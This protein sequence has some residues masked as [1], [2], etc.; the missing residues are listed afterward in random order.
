MKYLKLVLIV[1]LA[2]VST[3][4]AFVPMTTGGN[5]QRWELVNL[6]M[7]VHTNVVNRNTR[8]I[9]YYL[10]AN[11]YSAGNTAAELNAIRASFAQWQAISGTVLKFE[12]AGL[13]N[14]ADVNTTDNSNVVYWA[15]S[16]LV[17]NNLNISGTLGVTY[18]SFSMSGV[19]LQA[20]IVLNGAEND[21]YTD[22][23]SNSTTH[24]F[25]EGVLLHEIGHYIGLHH[26]PVG[27][28]SMLW[29]GG[30]GI[31]G[32][33]GLADDDVSGARLI[34][35][36]TNQLKNLGALTGSV[37]R[38]GSTIFGAAVFLED[39]NGNLVAGTVTDSSGVYRLLAVQPESYQ[40]RVCPLDPNSGDFL[41]RGSEISSAYNAADTSFLPTA[42]IA[43]NVPAGTNTLNL[44]VLSGTA[45]FRITDIRSPTA[46]PNS[47]RWSGT[48]IT[49][50]QGQSNFTVGVVSA[51]LPTSGATLSV[52]GTG[53]SV[54][55][56]TFNANL[57]GTGLN[58]MSV[59][60]SVASNAAPGP[61]TFIVQQ[62][63]NRAYANGFIEIAP[64]APDYN[65]DSF[66]DTFQ[67]KYF[68]LFTVA[69]AASTADPD[70]DGFPNSSE[71][72]AGT[73][74]TNATSLMKIDLV[75]HTVN[76]A[77]VTFRSVSGKR[78]Q[79]YSRALAETGAWQAVGA[80]VTAAGANTVASD[81]SGG[82]GSKFY[83]VAIAP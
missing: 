17:G 61:R 9:R 1:W 51:T 8:A 36:Q 43:V 40:V 59:V 56:T 13:M 10:G 25:A 76:G 69:N 47:Y 53:V 12:E 32:Q 5:Q 27:A 78:Y 48:P 21:W 2:A 83:R 81:T 20:D 22:F 65:F 23:S 54:G 57:S 26:S 24:F 44:T 41:V 3:A 28:A 62:G 74:P 35:A 14:A 7:S 72:L 4:P 30:E 75:Q 64:V 55:A 37:T 34:Y 6:P 60:L 52:A 16:T 42:N 70:G 66:D 80:P 79:L 63:T 68:P 45:P 19:F 11:G 49:M 73:N 15:T 33:V 50:W 31:Q 18:S 82:T 46:N 77:N 29:V 39:T 58:F 71:Y 38:N 67:R